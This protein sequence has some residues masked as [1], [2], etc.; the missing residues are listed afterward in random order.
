MSKRTAGNVATWSMDQW[1]KIVALIKRLAQ[2]PSTADSEAVRDWVRHLVELATSFEDRLPE[3]VVRAVHLLAEIAASDAV[4]GA[5]YRLLASVFLAEQ[6]G[7]NCWEDVL[8]LRHE[9]RVEFLLGE[10]ARTA[11]EE[12]ASETA[13]Q[14]FDVTLLLQIV[15]AI[16]QLLKE[17]RDS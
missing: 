5:F 13:V 7:T 11:A 10:V 3:P 9:P 17:R 4:W 12:Q 15:V 1:L 2:L 14:G 6:G 8:A 16:I